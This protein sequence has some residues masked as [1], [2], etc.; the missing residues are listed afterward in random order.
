MQTFTRREWNALV[1][2]GLVAAPLAAVA[3]GLDS[4]IAGVRIGI[5]SYS[6]RDRPLDAAIAAIHDVG[7]SYCELWQDHVERDRIGT[8][9]AAQRRDALRHW[10]LTAPLDVFRDVRRRF[11][12]AGIRLTAYNISFT[13]DF[14]DEEIA[15]AFDMA[16]ALGVDVITSSSKTDVAR[17]LDPFARKAGIRVGLHNHSNTQPGE[18]ATAKDFAD[19]LAGV[20]DMIAINLDIGHFTAADGDALAFLDAHHDRIVSLHL[21]DRKRHQ[22]DNVPWGDGDTPIVAVLHRLRDRGWNIPAN[23]EY[24]YKGADPVA[25]VRRCYQV[26]AGAP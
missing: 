6:F 10:R 9:P 24:Q 13:D 15:R 12:A 1:L 11:E 23:I 3:R 2:G 17:R 4:K 22:G 21:K 5:Q 18:V 20:S 16:K 7:L 14:T 8:V 26:P 25:D 19:A